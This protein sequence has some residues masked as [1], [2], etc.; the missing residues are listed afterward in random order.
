MNR[1]IHFLTIVLSLILSVAR[2]Q[3]TFQNLG[4]ES[5]TFIPIPGDPYDRVEFAAAM[6]G[7]TGYIGANPATTLL[8]NNYFLGTA[9]IGRHDA[10]SPYGPPLQSSYSLLL[11]AGSNPYAGIFDYLAATIAQSG[12][13]P[14]NANSLRLQIGRA[15]V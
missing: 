8:Y 6:P 15:H 11:Q 1:K 3:G 2:G 14:V 10:S 13:V 12:T 5:G 7:W 4:F 9:G